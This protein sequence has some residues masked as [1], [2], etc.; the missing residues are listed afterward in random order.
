MRSYETMFIVSPDIIGDAYQAII[1]KFKGI[2]TNLGTETIDLDDWGM[3]TLAYPIQKK[4]R[5]SYVLL[6]HNADPSAISEFERLLRIDENVLK[7][8][9]VQ[10][11][12]KRLAGQ[13]KQSQAVIDADTEEET[14]EEE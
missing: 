14:D 4:N 7:F 2:L 5:G 8:Q 9:T 12:P 6:R 1:E 11:D 13:L 10:V 3:R